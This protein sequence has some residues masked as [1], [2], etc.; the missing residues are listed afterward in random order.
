M[1]WRR[2]AYHFRNSSQ[3]F[4]KLTNSIFQNL[5]DQL[6]LLAMDSGH[7]IK[8][9]YEQMER[10]GEAQFDAREWNL[11]KPIM[12]I[13]EAPANPEIVKALIGFANTAYD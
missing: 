6:L 3:D 8:D 13:G 10:P 1:G 4:C 12:P 11:L 5:R 7:K 9:I 2:R